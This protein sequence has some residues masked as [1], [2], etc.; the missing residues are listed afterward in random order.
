MNR[1]HPT[2]WRFA[3]PLGLAGHLRNRQAI[4]AIAALLITVHALWAAWWSGT[5]VS[6]TNL[7]PGS[8]N[9]AELSGHELELRPEFC[10]VLI[11]I[12]AEWKGRSSPSYSYKLEAPNGEV[13][14]DYHEPV[15]PPENERIATRSHHTR[16]ARLEQ[17]Q[18]GTY[19][20]R[21]RLEQVAGEQ[22]L[23]AQIRVRRNVTE[24]HFFR[25]MLGLALL[26]WAVGK[27]R[28]R[29]AGTPSGS[30][31]P[32]VPSTPT[33]VPASPRLGG[34]WR[35]RLVLEGLAL[36][37]SVARTP[38]VGFYVA[39]IGLVYFVG[40]HSLE[41]ARWEA[42]KAVFQPILKSGYLDRVVPRG[43]FAGLQAAW[44]LGCAGGLAAFALY[45]VT[46]PVRLFLPPRPRR[47]FRARARRL[48]TIHA[49][50]ITLAA[51]WWWRQP[52]P[53]NAT[54]EEM[55]IALSVLNLTVLYLPALVL[56]QFAAMIETAFERLEPRTKP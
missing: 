2:R 1:Y 10:P 17:V 24:S 53:F 29:N 55:I 16:V 48:F 26:Y 6:A 18:A 38:L 44:V 49:A 20:L 31:A 11:E 34:N 14:V 54:Y 35:Q 30:L 4:L 9:G 22:L 25:N 33:S 36:G 39:W 28:Q 13:V 7:P 3:L 21:V 23:S 56:T 46:L 37:L 51:I 50:M 52:M 5:L 40:L 12:R 45:L 32:A 27:W 47:S 8:G 41:G 43:E 15:N 19:R 42:T